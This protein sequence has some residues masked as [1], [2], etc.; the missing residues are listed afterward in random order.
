MRTIEFRG[1]RVDNG[2]WIFGDLVHH[3]FDGTSRV[4]PITIKS[5]DNYPIEINPSTVGQFTGLFD[6]NGVKIFEGDKIQYSHDE[7]VYHGIIQ[8]ISC[9]GLKV[10]ITSRGFVNNLGVFVDSSKGLF[11]ENKHY[12]DIIICHKIQVIGNIHEGGEQ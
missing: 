11:L 5:K 9:F 3:V 7:D 12:H 1:K 8:Y 2:E 10:L 4:L 6:K